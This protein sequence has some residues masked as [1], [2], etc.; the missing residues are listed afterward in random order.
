MQEITEQN[1]LIR[2]LIE[3]QKQTMT[4]QRLKVDLK[5]KVKIPKF[6]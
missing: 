6:D 4:I 3:D 1:N 5:S 2:K